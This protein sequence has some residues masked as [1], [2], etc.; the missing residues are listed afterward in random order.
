VVQISKAGGKDF[1]EQAYMSALMVMFSIVEQCMLWGGK[2]E[3]WVIIV[4]VNRQSLINLSMRVGQRIITSLQEHF[5]CRLERM[6]IVHLST[7]ANLALS[8]F[9]NFADSRL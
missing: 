9:M 3:N 7:S 5:P 6:F 1:D 4:D 8:V 2:V